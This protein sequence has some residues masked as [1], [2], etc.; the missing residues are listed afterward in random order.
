MLSRPTAPTTG[1]ER[2][3]CGQPFGRQ[4]TGLVCYHYL[5]ISQ[6]VYPKAAPV[7]ML[8]ASNYDNFRQLYLEF[9]RTR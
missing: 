1:M 4:V 5:K 7:Q 2:V 9:W 8:E 6:Q 3:G